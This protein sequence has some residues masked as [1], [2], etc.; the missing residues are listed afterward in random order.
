MTDAPEE[1]FP[2]K[3]CV[4]CAGTGKVRDLPVTTAPFAAGTYLTVDPAVL[5]KYAIYPICGT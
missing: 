3:P 1:E 4:F 5:D 2:E